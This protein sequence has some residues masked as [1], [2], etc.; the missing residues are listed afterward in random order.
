[1]YS[2]MDLKYFNSAVVRNELARGAVDGSTTLV[3]Y[4][5]YLSSLRH[6]YQA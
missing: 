6:I 1:V 2:W 4:D 3:R 5:L